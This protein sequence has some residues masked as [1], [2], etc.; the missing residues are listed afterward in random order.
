MDREQLQTLQRP[1]KDAYRED[2]ASAL[3]TL[4][5]GGRLGETAG[6]VGIPLPAPSLDF[7]IRAMG[8][9]SAEFTVQG[10]GDALRR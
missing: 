4:R 1:L 5:A 6:P 3:V 2:P 8:F 7:L 9:L 10:K